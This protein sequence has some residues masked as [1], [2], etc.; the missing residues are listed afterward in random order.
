M[1][2]GIVTIYYVCKCKGMIV[3]V[4]IYPRQFLYRHFMLF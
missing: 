2:E 1:Y 4:T 3:N